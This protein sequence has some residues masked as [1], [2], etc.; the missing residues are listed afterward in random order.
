[1]TDID[2]DVNNS[3]EKS[4]KSAIGEEKERLAKIIHGEFP[5]LEDLYMK[6]PYERE[7]VLRSFIV[8]NLKALF[9]ECGATDWT[10][11]AFVYG[12]L[13][14]AYWINEDYK[15]NPD[16]KT[17]NLLVGNLDNQEF[18]IPRYEDIVQNLIE[19]MEANK[20]NSDMVLSLLCEVCGE[21]KKLILNQFVN[22][23]IAYVRVWV[24]TVLEN[25]TPRDI[26]EIPY[27]KNQ[28]LVYDPN[29]GIYVYNEKTG[30]MKEK[31]TCPFKIKKIVDFQKIGYRRSDEQIKFLIEMGGDILFL[32]MRELKDRLKSLCAGGDLRN[33]DSEIQNILSIVLSE[34][35]R[36]I[37]KR[38]VPDENSPIA[39]GVFTDDW[40]NL[41]LF[42]TL[43]DGIIPLDIEHIR[44][45]YLISKSLR[46]LTEDNLKR[47][48]RLIFEILK[49]FKDEAKRVNAVLTLSHGAISPFYFVLRKKKWLTKHLILYGQKGA[50]KSIKGWIIWYAYGPWYESSG[51]FDA[52]REFVFIDMLSLSTLPLYLND[53]KKVSKDILSMFKAISDG[54]IPKRGTPS[55]HVNKYPPL[56]SVIITANKIDWGGIED[57]GVI[58]RL[59]IG[60]YEKGAYKDRKI[61]FD[62]EEILSSDLKSLLDESA[63]WGIDYLNHTIEILNSRG[64]P[65]GGGLNILLSLLSKIKKDFHDLM[66]E[67]YPYFDMGLLSEESEARTHVRFLELLADYYFGLQSLF[68]Y[69][70]SKYPDIVEEYKDDLDW[71]FSLEDK[72]LFIRFMIE[73]WLSYSYNLDVLKGML[74]RIQVYL[75]SGEFGYEKKKLEGLV[76]YDSD[77]EEILISAG[78]LD[79]YKNT[80]RKDVGYDSLGRFAEDLAKAISEKLMEHG[81]KKPWIEIK[82]EIAGKDGRGKKRK[83]GAVSH[84]RCVVL[85]M[86]YFELLLNDVYEDHPTS[87]WVEFQDDYGDYKKGG[88]T[89][90][91]YDEAQYLIKRGVA[92]VCNGD[93]VKEYQDD[94]EGV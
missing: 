30:E 8:K 93:C 60:R 58:D 76:R 10:K 53:V 35:A 71:L 46:R 42:L 49:G 84:A 90:L 3:I 86:R 41:K 63:P 73:K 89:K 54:Y 61:V 25:R 9:K 29:K 44:P 64:T 57:T 62:G 68:D 52:E 5:D 7:V 6:G 19:S 92:T 45:I 83:L 20:H 69:W 65:G 88:V 21:S 94:G 34:I 11:R 13:W 39:V 17:L 43:E 70:K 28:N 91:D 24:K 50:G 48:T 23:I 18:G 22:S 66:I 31:I 80:L 33:G 55:Q 81:V 87:L 77:N 56:S 59:I 82:E 26:I 67:L 12:L 74:E 37:G 14:Y 36:R 79:Y 38:V 27:G 47:T 78:F 15:K 51:G 75:S 32:S 16:L 40:G 2:K 85:P 72:R 4:N 1:M